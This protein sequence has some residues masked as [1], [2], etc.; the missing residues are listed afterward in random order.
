ECFVVTTG[1][2]VSAEFACGVAAGA[3][4]V[5]AR[6]A[7]GGG[8]DGDV[9]AGSGATGTTGAAAGRGGADAVFFTTVGFTMSR[10]Y[11]T[12]TA[13]MTPRTRMTIRARNHKAEKMLRGGSSS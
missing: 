13:A 4:D 11:G 12:A 2:R 3:G 9:A 8:S 1:F 5:A 7:D 6:G 10:T